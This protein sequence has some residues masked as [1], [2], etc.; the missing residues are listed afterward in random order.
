MS[1]LATFCRPFV[2]FDPENAD[3]RRWLGEFHKNRSWGHC[4]VRFI[5]EDDYG[6]LLTQMNQMLISYYNKK[7]FKGK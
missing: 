2:Y 6:G 7:E 5:V 1:K 3:H 4:P